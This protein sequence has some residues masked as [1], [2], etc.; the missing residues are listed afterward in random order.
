MPD[1]AVVVGD[2][3]DLDVAGVLQIAFEIDRV[4]REVRLSLP[5]C[6]FELFFGFFGVVD[7]FHSTAATTAF[8]L[9]SHREPI[10]LA[11]LD[12]FL[13]VFDRVGRPRDDRHV[14]RL[15]DLASLRLL[16]QCLH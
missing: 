6:A 2:N 1:V 9:D 12:D 7:D 10:L 3:L 5:F 4:V 14:S 13:G 15:H 8:G 16:A 11:E